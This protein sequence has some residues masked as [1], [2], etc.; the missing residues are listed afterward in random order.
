LVVALNDHNK[1][2]MKLKA[3]DRKWMDEVMNDLQPQMLGL[4]MV[5]VI[6]DQSEEEYVRVGS[7]EISH[8]IERDDVPEDW[9]NFDW[10]F[11]DRYK[12]LLP[13][14]RYV[15]EGTYR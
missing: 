10:G 11:W 14:N 13:E 7:L 15:Y 8:D 2:M 3:E 1:A 4:Q 6:P 9:W 12:A 5:F